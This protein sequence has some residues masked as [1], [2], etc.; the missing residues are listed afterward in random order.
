MSPL[1]TREV[2][3]QPVAQSQPVRRDSLG[4]HGRAV[5]E[6]CAR[7]ATALGLLPDAQVRLRFA[8]YLHDIGKRRIPRAVVDKPGPLD[9]GEW[10]VM[11]SHPVLGEQ[12]LLDAGLNDVAAFVRSHHERPDGSG[13]PDG[14]RGE[15]IPIESRILAVA[16][17]YHAMISDRPYSEAISVT[18]A[19]RELDAGANTQFDAD[20]VAAFLG[21]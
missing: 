20:V 17:A 7:I 11:R 13:Y 1:I 12:I 8:A 2:S 15:Q 10:A 6:I 9:A 3:E 19:R 14:L 18:E 4:D 21:L 16:D 5:G